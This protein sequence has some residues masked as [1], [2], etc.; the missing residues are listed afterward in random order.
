[1][2]KRIVSLLSVVLMLAMLAVPFTALA[3]EAG[4]EV[5]IGAP[6]K[7]A[8]GDVIDVPIT[9]DKNPGIWGINWKIYYDS[10][11]LRFDGIEFK[12]EFADL[13]LLDTNEVKYPIVINGM[14]SSVTENV[15]TTGVIAVVHFKVY[16]GAT[17][18][19]T[20]ISMKA[21]AGNNINVD[22]EDV[23]LKVNEGKID[24]TEGLTS[25]D[26]KDDYPPKEPLQEKAQVNTPVGHSSKST[27]G[28]HKWLWIIIGAV[29][30]LGVVVVIW[31]FSG[32]DEED[33]GEPEVLTGAEKEAADEAAFLAMLGANDTLTDHTA[34]EDEAA[35]LKMLED[36]ENADEQNPQE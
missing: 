15:S 27:E 30:L 11:I 1:M 20:V 10:Q 23:A 9:I 14:G 24:V 29:I 31:L 33:E 26:N 21:D 16:V 7:A 17:L 28:G 5:T 36:A 19:E 8:Q 34:D 4:V 32:S 18:G 3:D 12:D 35:F 22:G 6:E 13:G 2:K 25:S